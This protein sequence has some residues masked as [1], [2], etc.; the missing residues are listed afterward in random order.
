M[1]VNLRWSFR[2]WVINPKMKKRKRERNILLIRWWWWVNTVSVSFKVGRVNE[3]WF[4]YWDGCIYICG[5]KRTEEDLKFCTLVNYAFK[6]RVSCARKVKL[7][8]K[9][10]VGC[11]GELLIIMRR[12]NGVRQ[13]VTVFLLFL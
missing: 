7:G 10:K 1:G 5:K 3:I 9:K 13:Y 11:G 4:A 2:E 12:E 6:S 8:N